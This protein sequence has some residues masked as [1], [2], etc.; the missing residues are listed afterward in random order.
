[1]SFRHYRQLNSVEINQCQFK[2]IQFPYH[3]GFGNTRKP[4]TS[5]YGCVVESFCSNWKASYSVTPILNHDQG[6]I[7]QGVSARFKHLK[8][9][10]R[11][12]RGRLI[13]HPK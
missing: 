6:T 13:A 11:H 9:P 7:V 4:T 1:M 2:Q 3:T 5:Q 12:R 10:R 8:Q